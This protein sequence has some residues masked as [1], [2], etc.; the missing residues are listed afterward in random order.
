RGSVRSR[1]ERRVVSMVERFISHGALALR[2]AWLLEQVRLMATVDGLTGLANRSS[3]DEAL[4][5]ELARAARQGDDVGLLMLDLDYFKRLNDRHG[6]R[7]GDDVLRRVAE[8][9]R[10]GCREFDTAARYGGE[11]FAIVLPRT[12]P[13]EATVVAERLRDMIGTALHSESLT[14]SV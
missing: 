11:E 3:F 7:A 2:N 9:L 1:I 12:P 14:V 8:L 6:H 5:H 13:Q 10:L 4:E